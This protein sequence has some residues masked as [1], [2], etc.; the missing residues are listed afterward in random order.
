MLKVEVEQERQLV[1]IHCAFLDNPP[2][3]LVA[4]YG[5]S[6]LADDVILAVTRFSHETTISLIA[7][8]LL[9]YV[10]VKQ[11]AGVGH[12]QMRI[13]VVS[14]PDLC[15]VALFL[16]ANRL[17]FLKIALHYDIIRK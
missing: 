9:H 3:F 16:I 7:L 13:L 1:A 4:D 12:K 10:Q 11:I 17:H 5:S 8:C 2:Q 14:L 15:L 6:H